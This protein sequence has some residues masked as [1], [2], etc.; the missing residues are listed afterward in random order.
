[1][2]ID[3][4]DWLWRSLLASSLAIVVVL[5]LRPV[6]LRWIGAGSVLWL[7]LL[8]PV[9]MLASSL[10]APE[11]RLPSTAALPGEDLTEAAQ[12]RTAPVA[13]WIAV[14][15]VA[16]NHDGAALAPNGSLP[17]L[18]LLLWLAG[19][20]LAALSLAWRQR[21]FVRRLGRLHARGDGVLIASA[22]DIGPLVT[23]VLRPRIVLPSDFEQ[24]FDPLQQRLILAHE[25]CHL[26]RGD[27]I[28]NLLFF[29]EKPLSLDFDAAVEAVTAALKQEGFGVLTRIDV[30]DTLQQKIGVAFRRYLILGTCN[31]QLA[32]RALLAEPQIGLLLPCNAVVQE[33]DDNT[34]LVSIA[35]P[36]AMF[37][38]VD[39]AE[40]RAVADDAEQRLRRV[41]DALQ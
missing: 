7:W 11:L 28:V 10:P 1:M 27:L 4:L 30:R 26:R 41:M 35:D 40:L 25:R 13:H 3:L 8:L 33:T 16:E 34:V 29:F 36:K 14:P 39:K 18:L 23:G 9:A 12:P 37:T 17:T 22:A 2:T 31:P 24:R 15:A 6:R 32:H 5:A 38:L 19:V 20:A 21:A